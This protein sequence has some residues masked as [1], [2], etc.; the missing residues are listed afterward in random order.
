[1]GCDLRES[2][3]QVPPLCFAPVG[4]TILWYP[5]QVNRD[6]PNP[7]TEL[8]SRPKWRDLLFGFPGQGS[9]RN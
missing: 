5:Q 1:M 9:L 7:A 3:P 8:S 4:M 6:H 2:K